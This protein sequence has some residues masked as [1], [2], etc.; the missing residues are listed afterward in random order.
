MSDPAVPAPAPS[1][2]AGPP[3]GAPQEE[4]RKDATTW[5]V[6]SAVSAFACNGWCLSLAGA[7]MCFLAMQAADQ[8]NVAD[9]AAKLKWG[10]ILTVAG[11]VLGLLLGLM[12]LLYVFVWAKAIAS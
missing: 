2:L 7:V 12:L 11:I 3:P 6:I 10:K 5:L 9:S 8:G 4:L 1:D